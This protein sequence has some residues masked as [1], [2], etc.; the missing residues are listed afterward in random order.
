MKFLHR[1]VRANETQFVHF[2]S[3]DRE[4]ALGHVTAPMGMLNN[5][6]KG[7]EHR[8]GER[9][10]SCIGLIWETLGDVEINPDIANR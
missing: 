8:I 9:S 5:Y 2:G 3:G 4:S 10:G 1:N 6:P 7:I